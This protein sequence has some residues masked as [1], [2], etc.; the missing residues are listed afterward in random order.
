MSHD[1]ALQYFVLASRAL[2][3]TT[4]SPRTNMAVTNKMLNDS[5]EVDCIAIT[6]QRKYFR[7][8]KSFVKRSLRP[9]EWQLSP[10]QGTTH[11]PRLGRERLLN[12]AAALQLITERTNVPVPKL[13]SCF[14]DAGAVYLV[15]EYIDGV[16]MDSLSPEER[17]IVQNELEHHL[18]TIHEL[19]S[20]RLGGV[21]GFV[22]PPFR[23]GQKCF[24]DQWS[25][26][27]SDLEEFVFCHNDLSQHNVI[28]D[29]QTLKVR[30][31]IDWEYSGYWPEWFEW[32]FF[33]RTGQ[34]IALDGETDDTDSVISFLKS[35]QV[36]PHLRSGCT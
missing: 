23:A 13:H 28:V 31:I 6:H 36:R 14:E 30:A 32:P 18:R 5:K 35:R 22:I 21:S 12:E 26:T 1:L 2:Y 10:T 7:S 20:Q 19:R 17:D 16:G 33:R 4:A 11:V 25:L 3:F 27:T 24:I 8:G 9:E 34:S 15:M 29:P